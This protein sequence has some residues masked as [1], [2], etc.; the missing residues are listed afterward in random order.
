MP[1]AFSFGTGSPVD[2]AGLGPGI[3]QKHASA[4]PAVLTSLKSTSARSRVVSTETPPSH[5]CRENA[6]Q[7]LS[8]VLGSMPSLCWTSGQNSQ[9]TYSLR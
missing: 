7:L 6:G 3:Q 2:Q 8:A 4:H 5:P 1:Q 9:S